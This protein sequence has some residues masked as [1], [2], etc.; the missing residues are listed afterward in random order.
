LTIDRSK[1]IVRSMT[2]DASP[3]TRQSTWP[4]RR[5]SE[6][7]WRLIEAAALRLFAQKGFAAVGIRKIAHEAGVSTAALYHHMSTKDDLLPA[8]IRQTH[9]RYLDDARQAVSGIDRPSR[10]IAMLVRHH[11]LGHGH[12]QHRALVVMEEISDRFSEMA[13]ALLGARAAHIRALLGV[14]PHAMAETPG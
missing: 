1:I 12:D 2:E 3:A 14:R 11:V 4:A 5:P 7:T 6:Q 10:R 9:K 13:L 8:I